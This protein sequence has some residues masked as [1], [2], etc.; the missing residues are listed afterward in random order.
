MEPVP[1]ADLMAPPYDGNVANLL[2]RPVEKF[3]D[4]VALAHEGETRTYS[5]LYDRA[6]AIAAGLHDRGIG[7][8]DRVGLYLPNGVA[9]PET[10]WACIHAGVVAS[11]LNPQ[12]RRREITYQLDHSEA[13]A[14]VCDAERE[15]HAAPVAEELGV[16]VI[17]SD[18]DSD[19]TTLEDLAAGGG[20]V[21]VSREDEDTLLQPYTSGTTGQP[22]GV[23]LTHKN[24]RVQMVNAISGYTGSQIW[25][26]S[27]IILPMY[28]ITGCLGVLSGTATGRTVRMLRPDEWDPER[29]LEILT[30]HDVP[31]FTGVATMFNDLLEA[32]DPEEHDLETLYRAGQGG[33]K[34]PEPVHEE[35]EETI[36]VAVSEGYGLTE[37]TAGT[38]T[39]R[40]STLGD[41]LGS[42]GQPLGHT[43]SKI[44]DPETGER[45]PVGETG[46]LVMR[47]PQVMKG[48]VDEENTR[49]AFT[50]DGFFKS[51]DR[52]W[53][54][55]D[56]YHYIVG[57]EKEMILTAGYNVYPAEVERVLYDHPE[58]HE[59]AVFGVPD[60]RRGETVAA[61]VTLA[62]DGDLT[63]QDIK[64]YVLEELAP[65]KHPRHVL[66]RDEL[67]KT[68][69]GKIQKHRLAEEFEE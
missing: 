49:E 33:D 67:P 25:G 40:S 63:E 51:G 1:A 18:P 38:H 6:R 32:Y 27:L 55:E 2:A 12:Y 65:Y 23:L 58:I 31:A 59:A 56:N 61:G 52:A 34:L 35:F 22:K 10:L 60:D 9:F 28:H 29:V 45:V 19:F 5:E 50:D 47:G 8:G 16:E 44:I 46:E 42:V 30:E 15:E 64:D 66:I 48:Y 7:P 26:D 17:S 14:V 62:P 4:T 68:G 37:T 39:I 21:L 53:K 20:D 57:R 36:D 41:K 24:F 11:P 43:D 54:D 13:E 3:P 69:S